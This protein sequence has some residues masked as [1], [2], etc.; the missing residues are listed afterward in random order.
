LIW[1]ENSVGS[2]RRIAARARFPGARQAFAYAVTSAHPFT[3]FPRPISAPG[4]IAT[5]SAAR[6]LANAAMAGL[7]FERRNQ[8]LALKVAT[9][10]IERAVADLA[11]TVELCAK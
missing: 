1:L 3:S 4:S 10:L 6:V 7:G 8:Q 2:E 9:K 11:A 5:E